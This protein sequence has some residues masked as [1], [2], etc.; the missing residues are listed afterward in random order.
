MNWNK[1]NRPL[2]PGHSLG[3]Q[4]TVLIIILY[5]NNDAL[6]RDKMTDIN[7]KYS[8]SYYLQRLKGI[9][10]TLCEHGLGYCGVRV[11]VSL[12]SDS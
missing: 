11:W 1:S 6:Y 7:G 5:L 9:V 10:L 3:Y 8:N 12:Y 2:P 4:T